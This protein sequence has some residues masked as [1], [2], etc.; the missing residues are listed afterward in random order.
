MRRSSSNSSRDGET[1]EELAERWYNTALEAD[2][3]GDDEVAYI[4]LDLTLA[5]MLEAARSEAIWRVMA[6]DE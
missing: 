3:A 4:Y 1:I 2:R 5:V 6:G